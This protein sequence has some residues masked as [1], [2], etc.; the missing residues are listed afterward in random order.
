MKAKLKTS[1]SLIAIVGAVLFL[2]AASPNA[3]LDFEKA[4]VLE[5]V[6]GR[7]EEAIILYQKIV[8]EAEDDALAA[9]AQLHIGTCYE[10]LG[11]EEAQKAYR[12]VVDKYPSQQEAVRLAGEALAR[13]T[14]DQKEPAGTMTVREFMRSGEFSYDKIS[15]P[16]IGASEVAI[17]SDGQIF[18]YT[19]WMTG[20]LVVKNLSTGKTY[21]LYDVNWFKSE[22]FFE[23]PVLSPDEKRMAYLSFSWANKQ[24]VARIDTDSV[25]GGNRET[26]YTDKSAFYLYP[27]D[28]SSDGN[29]ILATFE[30]ADRS[31]SLV[32]VS[33]KQKKMQR[34]VTLNWEYPRRAQYSPDGR[35]IAYDSTKDGER[36]IYLISSDGLQERVLVDSPGE[37][38]SPLWSRDGRF[39]L[40]R[41]N[42][43]GNWDLF[44]LPMEDGQPVGDPLL[45]KSNLGESTF[46]RSMTSDGKL[47]Y[48]E[49]VVG[50]DIVLMERPDQSG[51]NGKFRKLPKTHTRSQYGAQF[52]PDAKRLVY[53]VGPVYPFAGGSQILRIA[54]LNGKVIKDLP[55]RREIRWIWSASFSPDGKKIAVVGDDGKRQTKIFLLSAETGTVLRQFAPLTQQ[56]L[57]ILLNRSNRGGNHWSRDSRLLYF[58]GENRETKEIVSVTLD[59]ES[60][61]TVLKVLPDIFFAGGSHVARVSPDENYLIMAVNTDSPARQEIEA[62]LVLRSLADGSEKVLRRNVQIFW[63]TWDHD[64]RHVFY[65][66]GKDVDRLYRLSIETGTE[67]V[68][69]ESSKDL[70]ITDVSRDGKYLVFQK[71][72][73]DWRIWV[74]ENFLPE[75]RD[76]I[77]RR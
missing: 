77:A 8:S 44:V 36:K 33:T 29:N 64:S 35:F 22:E 37:D 19:D 39:L 54:D 1:V 69:S 53:I 74:L 45:I 52:L 28:W 26:L 27:N 41:S 75:S 42:R 67:E 59:V 73:Q 2:Q 11:R 6:E 7:L 65:K 70:M 12:A 47:F 68:F 76:Q 72:E 58:T 34:L 49:Q 60:G 13:L 55:S 63:I 16:T 24:E 4:L 30:A 50:P 32:T 10:K 66:K 14:A 61:K 40:F 43:S 15:D 18:V 5:E 57:V 3:K 56:G 38:D 17:S 23:A 20:D 71:E 31:V 21:A 48:A 9:Q 51:T 62:N 25:Q 46:L